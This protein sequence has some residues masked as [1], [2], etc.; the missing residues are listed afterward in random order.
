M[1]SRHW[2]TDLINEIFKVTDIS[3]IVTMSILWLYIPSKCV[4]YILVYLLRL[5]QLN[6]ELMLI[7]L[8]TSWQTIFK[9]QEIVGYYSMLGQ[10][11]KM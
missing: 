10:S 11:M 3:D 4:L 9:N 6:T 7:N 1:Q 8:L 5:H 2:K